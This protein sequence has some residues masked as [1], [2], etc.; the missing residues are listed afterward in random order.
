MRY[1]LDTHTMIWLLDDST[2]LSEKVIKIIQNPENEIFSSIISFY[3]LAIKTNIGKISLKL[4]NNKIQKELSK[5]SIKTIPIK[6]SHL[7]FYASLYQISNH[8]DPFDRLLIST[9]AVEKSVILSKDGK[10]QNYQSIIKA[11]W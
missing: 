7:D 3:E 11:T 5:Q 8:K 4:N 2:Q 6:T 10:F 1:L 9:A